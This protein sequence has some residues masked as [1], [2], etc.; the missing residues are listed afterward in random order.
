[1]ENETASARLPAVPAPV[2]AAAS[3]GDAPD[4]LDAT[5]PLSPLQEG[6]LFHSVAHPR[7]GAD[8]QQFV[9]VSPEALDPVAFARAWELTVARHAILRTSFRWH[10][11]PRPEQVVHRD[12]A[13]PFEVLDWRA[14]PPEDLAEHRGAFLA[15][16]RARGFD[17]AVAP[18][19]RV[20]LLRVGERR[21][22]VVW[23]FHHLL[24]DGRSFLT[25]LKDVY[26]AYDAVRAGVA[27]SPPPP[28]P[29]G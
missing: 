17:L 18:C 12:V 21:Y 8:F 4:A 9:C 28:C 7:P 19:L 2:A 11:L 29:F 6:M 20:T 27:W 22:D 14:V 10:D 13:V 5:Y 26:A 1:M 3:A 15:H 25:V 24:L 16:D 23:S